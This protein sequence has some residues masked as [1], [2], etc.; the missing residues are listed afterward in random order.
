MLVFEIFK[1]SVAQNGTSIPGDLLANPNP[2]EITHCFNKPVRGAASISAR[3]QKV[4]DI[5]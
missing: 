3:D 2:L 4:I 1:S 5:M